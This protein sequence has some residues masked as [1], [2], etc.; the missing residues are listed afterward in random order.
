MHANLLFKKSYV[1]WFLVVLLLGVMLQVPARLVWGQFG[2]SSFLPPQA[3]LES[4]QG[5]I[6]NGQGLLRYQYQSKQS[7]A[8]LELKVEWHLGLAAWWVEG[9]PFVLRVQHIG[10]ELEAKFLLSGIDQFGLALSGRVHPLLLN[11]FLKENQAWMSGLGQVHHLRLSV[12]QFPIVDIPK[13]LKGL[14]SRQL[15]LNRWPNA[16]VA[17]QGAVAWE[18]GDT[19]F[20]AGQN[21]IKIIYPALVLRFSQSAGNLEAR[22]TPQD[23]D[24]TL[25]TVSLSQ[26]GWLNLL[27]DGQLKRTVPSLPMPYVSEGQSLFKYKEK[28]F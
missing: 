28:V 17:L 14:A 7:A 24:L 23:K 27:V 8:T 11:P 1:Y 2:M 3:Q 21:P 5:T 4:I 19:Y 10:S 18:G 12:Q 20:L 6:W 22:L 13:V 9:A 25:A 16:T 26:D 15:E